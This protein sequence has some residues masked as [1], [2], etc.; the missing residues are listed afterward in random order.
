[1][2]AMVCTYHVI[3]SAYTDNRAQLGYKQDLVGAFHLL[4]LLVGCWCLLRS[5]AAGLDNLHQIII[6][7]VA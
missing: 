4:G 6:V 3:E 5:I 1:M 7:A 2:Q